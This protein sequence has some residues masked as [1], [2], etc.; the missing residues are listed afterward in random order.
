MFYKIS[1]LTK[2]F[3]FVVAPPYIMTIKIEYS[4]KAVAKLGIAVSL[5]VLNYLITKVK[6]CAMR[7]GLTTTN[8]PKH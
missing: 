3:L 8:G 2:C 5:E 1:V 4:K 6:K 7:I